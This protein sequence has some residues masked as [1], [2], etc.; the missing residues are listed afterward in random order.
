NSNKNQINDL[1]LICLECRDLNKN[2]LVIAKNAELKN[3]ELI[4]YEA[5]I[6]QLD[7]LPLFK[8]EFKINFNIDHKIFYTILKQNDKEKYSIIELYQL[9][10]NAKSSGIKTDK[11]EIKLHKYFSNPLLFLSSLFIAA[12]L[13]QFRPR[14]HRILRYLIIGLLINFTVYFTDAFLSSVVFNIYQNIILIVYLPK[15]ILL[16]IFYHYL[17]KRISL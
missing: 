17:K 10:K 9:I 3:N 4:L 13:S 5:Q 1:N 16:L 14:E 2:S 12:L 7:K 6:N 8:S 11:Y 15:I